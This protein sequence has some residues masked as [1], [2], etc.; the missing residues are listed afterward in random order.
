MEGVVSCKRVQGCKLSRHIGSAAFNQSGSRL[1]IPPKFIEIGIPLYWCLHPFDDPCLP[2]HNPAILWW[3]FN[4][5]SIKSTFARRWPVRV[6]LRN[7]TFSNEISHTSIWYTLTP[8]L[9]SQSSA[10]LRWFAAV[11][12]RLGGAAVGP[13]L[14]EMVV[15]LYR[16][17]EGNAA[18][19][20]PGEGHSS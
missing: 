12:T 1:I 11:T 7:Q 2:S 3:P 4:E 6:P 8:F 17:A 13:H 15:P 16:L 19:T 9:F 10:A 5:T 20:V 18:K 14:P